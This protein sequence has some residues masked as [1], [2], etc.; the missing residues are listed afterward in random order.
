MYD[1]RYGHIQSVSRGFGLSGLGAVS[2][3]QFMS[4]HQIYTRLSK[5]RDKKKKTRAHAAQL[6][7]QN[8]Q[9]YQ[10]CMAA[11]QAPV[12][13][14]APVSPPVSTQP[15]PVAPPVAPPA[16]LQPIPYVT[17]PGGGGPVYETLP[18]ITQP[19][20]PPVTDPPVTPPIPSYGTPLTPVSYTPMPDGW[21]GQQY[22][23]QYIPQ[24]YAP[25]TPAAV[26]SVPGTVPAGMPVDINEADL[27]G[28][29]PYEY[30]D[31]WGPI[32]VIEIIIPK[33]TPGPTSQAIYGGSTLPG[34]QMKVEDF[35]SEYTL[36]G[37]QW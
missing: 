6:A 28:Q 33:T 14:P 26:P 3:A 37:G 34:G 36:Q 7:A 29:G 2:C 35:T 5:K 13:Q 25:T 27:V 30:W 31:Q 11:A 10:Q 24:D 22:I 4:L 15:P 8:L 23:P 19:V 32:N 12:A 16:P 18:P 21:N 1:R 20:E 17:Y 9:K